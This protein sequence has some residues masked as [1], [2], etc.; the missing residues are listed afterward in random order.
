MITTFTFQLLVN[1]TSCTLMLMIYFCI[2]HATNVFNNRNQINYWSFLNFGKTSDWFPNVLLHIKYSWLYRLLYRKKF[3]K[4]KIDRIIVE[5]NYFSRK[6]KR[7]SKFMH[8]KWD[9]ANLG[10]VDFADLI[11]DIAFQNAR[12]SRL[13]LNNYLKLIVFV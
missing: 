8:R 5:F 1:I 6:V 10:E 7:A 3:F 11:D 2:A 13:F 9:V 4:T 12:R